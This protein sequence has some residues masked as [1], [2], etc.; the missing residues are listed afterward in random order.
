[1]GNCQTDAQRAPRPARSLEGV[2]KRKKEREVRVDSFCTFS[3]NTRRESKKPRVMPPELT[4]DTLIPPR[5]WSDGVFERR[6]A[7][8]PRGAAPSATA[9]VLNLSTAS[10]YRC[11]ASLPRAQAEIHLSLANASEPM[12]CFDDGEACVARARTGGAT[13]LAGD[14]S[15]AAAVLLQSKAMPALAH[16]IVPDGFLAP[17]APVHGVC[18][19]LFALTAAIKKTWVWPVH[20]VCLETGVILMQNE[21]GAA[22]LAQAECMGDVRARAPA[23]PGSLCGAHGT[24]RFRPAL[25]PRPR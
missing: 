4:L 17:G 19:E 10:V 22:L 20:V 12:Q 1:M 16:P 8:F 5:L 14:G 7:H 15:D 18:D 13:L 2:Q 21:A 11:A 3:K 6:A 24:G 25:A 23:H 9:D